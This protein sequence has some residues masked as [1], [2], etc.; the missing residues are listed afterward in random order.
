MDPWNISARYMHASTP[1]LN[2]DFIRPLLP[3]NFPFALTAPTI[4]T[5][6]APRPLILDQ[7]HL[8]LQPTLPRILP[9][10]VKKE[11]NYGRPKLL[12]P[13]TETFHRHQ[14]KLSIPP[15]LKFLESDHFMERTLLSYQHPPFITPDNSPHSCSFSEIRQRNRTNT[16]QRDDVLSRVR[17]AGVEEIFI[18]TVQPQPQ[19]VLE[20]KRAPKPKSFA[21]NE[22]NPPVKKRK[23]YTKRKDKNKDKLSTY[24]SKKHNTKNVLKVR[25]NREQMIRNLFKNARLELRDAHRK[26]HNKTSKTCAKLHKIERTS[27]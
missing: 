23:K 10:H 15:A 17:K 24:K 3:V 19:P 27:V 25:I 14:D 6:C 26:T 8:N 12:L 11:Y 9:S 13:I 7:N 22:E 5:P 20:Y 16:V 2:A 4:T 18:E 21:S 1:R